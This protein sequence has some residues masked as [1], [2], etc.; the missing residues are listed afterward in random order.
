MRGLA[1][2]PGNGHRR[3]RR[4][5]PPH[6]RHDQ[7]ARSSPDQPGA[8]GHCRS[9]RRTARLHAVALRVRRSIDGAGRALSA[10]HRRVHEIFGKRV[11][12]YRMR[13]DAGDD[14][15]DE[16]RT[17]LARWLFNHI[18]SDDKAYSESVKR[19]LNDFAHHHEQG[20]WMRRTVHRLLGH[21]GLPKE[22]TPCAFRPGE[23]I[24]PRRDAS[25]ACAPASSPRHM[26]RQ[27]PSPRVF[28]TITDRPRLVPPCATPPPPKT[29]RARNHRSRRCRPIAATAAATPASTTSTTTS[30]SCTGSDWRTGCNGIR[31]RGNA[32]GRV[33]T[34]AALLN[35]SNAACA[36]AAYISEGPPPM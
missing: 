18:R 4:T 31:T 34:Y 25:I 30:C 19:H 24:R 35:S 10:A 26:R 21:Q 36:F 9:A 6:R 28:G 23:A 8:G 3:D 29:I 12:E 15:L 27:W 22:R 5:A 20:G 1:G 13:F 14:V 11:Q 16:L 33:P 17:M 2:R 32:A 7:P